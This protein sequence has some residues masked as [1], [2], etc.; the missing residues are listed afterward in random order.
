MA[1]LFT[2]L[3]ASDKTFQLQQLQQHKNVANAS[4]VLMYHVLFG[5]YVRGNKLC[6]LYTN[7]PRSSCWRVISY[8]RHGV[9]QATTD[10]AACRHTLA[11]EDDVQLSHNYT[12]VQNGPKKRTV[13]LDRITLQQLMIEK[14][15][16]R[17]K[18]QNFV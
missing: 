14:R 5:R 9:R 7:M 13:L 4:S 17:Q 12:Q 11:L 6:L 8:L 10:T 1:R 3:K 15:V 18:F 16:I 2:A